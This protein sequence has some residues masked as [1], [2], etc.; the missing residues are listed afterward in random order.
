[1]R[2]NFCNFIKKRLQ[3]RCFPGNIAK[4]L[5][6]SFS[7]NT[8]KRLLLRCSFLKCASATV[9]YLSQVINDIWSHDVVIALNGNAFEFLTMF[10][11]Q[12]T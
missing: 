11:E 3:N 10:Y 2:L 9:A 7:Q 4:F 12:I 8:G 6:T 1:M 5:R